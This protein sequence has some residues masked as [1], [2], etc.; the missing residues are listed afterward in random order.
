MNILIINSIGKKKWGGGE[1]WMIMAASGLMSLGHH[2][3]IACKKDSILALRASR[4]NI[5]V[6]EIAAISD[7]DF[8]AVARFYS[9]FKKFKP[10]AIIGC[11]NKD[12][13]VA[14]LAV[15]W[16]GLKT[17]VFSRQGLQLMRD[18][19]WYKV[20]VKYLCDG[21]ITNTH[22]IKKLY[23]GFLP[24]PPDFIQVVYNGVEVF[25]SEDAGF[26]FSAFFPSRVNDPVIVL[27]TGRLA[28]QKGFEYLIHAAKTIIDQTSNVF[29]FVAGCGKLENRLRKLIEKLKISD[30]FHLLGFVNDVHPLLAG[31]HVFVIPSLY[32]GMPN[33]VLEAMAHQLPVVAS[34]V[35]GVTELIQNGHNG[36]VV[37][38]RNVEQITSALK[39]LIGDEAKRKMFGLRAAELVGNQ[40]SVSKMVRELEE[41]LKS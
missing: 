37:E 40:F 18:G 12:W 6:V 15:K 2:A 20:T 23:E 35:N 31:S 17:K 28:H 4:S 1:K 27:S 19:W 39:S 41:V 11:Q 33:S 14:S 7:F 29:F 13:R 16:A 25:P 36:Y 22:T 8:W 38:P 5:P 9:F 21:I 32:E 10:D 34:N 24:V 3:A 26:D 30:N